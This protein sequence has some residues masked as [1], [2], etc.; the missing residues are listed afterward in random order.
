MS[1]HISTSE[2]E[3]TI[4]SPAVSVVVPTLHVTPAASIVVPSVALSPSIRHSSRQTRK[5]NR[6]LLTVDSGSTLASK[7]NSS[8]VD[9]VVVFSIP[10]PTPASV[11]PSVASIVCTPSSDTYLLL[12]N[13]HVYDFRILSNSALR[14]AK[15]FTDLKTRFTDITG[16][17]PSTMF[18][19][20]SCTQHT[21]DALSFP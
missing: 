16:D 13:I 10:V 7:V 6:Y 8:S 18:A 1:N 20:V 12:V 5:P 19:G 4:P 3:S 17:A 21:N 11:F 9:P 14:V 15:L 2:I